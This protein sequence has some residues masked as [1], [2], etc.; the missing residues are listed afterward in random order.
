MIDVSHGS[1]YNSFTIE[2]RQGCLSPGWEDPTAKPVIVRHC[3]ATVNQ[4]SADKSGRPPLQV[5]PHSRGKE[6]GTA[7]WIAISPSP[8]LMI[9]VFVQDAN[10]LIQETNNDP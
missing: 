9:G 10:H 5:P 4:Q 6:V 8:I 2:S 7:C 1:E 3:P